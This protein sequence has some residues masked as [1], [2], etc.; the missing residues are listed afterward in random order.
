LHDFYA[1][2][3][4]P[5]LRPLLDKCLEDPNFPRVGRTVFGRWLREKCKFKYRKLF[6]KPVYLERTDVAAH[7][8]TFLLTLRHLRSVGYKPFYQDE[9]WTSPDQRRKCSWQ[10]LLEGEDLQVFKREYNGKCLSDADGWTGGFTVKSGEGRVIINHIGSEDGLLEGAED[11]FISKKT[12]KDYHTSMNSKHWLEWFRKVVKLIPEKSVIIIDRVPYHRD[13]VIGTVMPKLHW[14]K[15]RIVAWFEQHKVP[16]PNLVQAYMELTKASLIELSKKYPVQEKFTV[17]I[18]ED[19]EKDVKVLFLPVAHC[20]LNAIELI[21]AYVKGKVSEQNV[22]GGTQRVFQLTLECMKLV[23]SS[24]WKSCITHA[25]KY[26]QK[27]WDRDKLIERNIWDPVPS[28]PNLVIDL[29]AQT[30]DSE[31]SDSD[32]SGDG[33]SADELLDI[34]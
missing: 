14:R 17:Q 33:L 11:I 1:R 31:R 22:I 24:L 3:E 25:Q 18:V 30:S 28:N 15:D 13:R 21:W 34:D 5:K 12:G 6:N 27:F 32:V 8:E 4:Y 19:S 2:K 26:E 20:E 10:C 23:D 29:G 16:L 9:T 7:R